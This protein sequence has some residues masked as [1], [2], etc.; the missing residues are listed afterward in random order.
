MCKTA[1]T[2]WGGLRE[3]LSPGHHLLSDDTTERSSAGVLEL[4]A[5]TSS[6]N[7]RSSKTGD[8]FHLSNQSKHLLA[9]V[10]KIEM[11]HQ[12]KK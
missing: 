6:S 2:E 12:V 5:G 10:S 3:D 1:M 7:M 8:I 11:Y 9:L 4:R